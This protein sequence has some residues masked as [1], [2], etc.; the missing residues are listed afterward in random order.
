MINKFG[1]SQEISKSI[2][3]VVAQFPQVQQ[4]LIF[5][6]RARGDFRPESDID[7]AVVAPD[8]SLAEFSQLATAI[9]NLD[10]VFGVDVVHAD[11]LKNTT[12][13]AHI[14]RDGVSFPN[15]GSM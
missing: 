2:I 15:P 4:L 3:D 5:G 9:D 6:S 11:T 14:Q 10:I 8:M 12:L 1:L 7:L 13:L